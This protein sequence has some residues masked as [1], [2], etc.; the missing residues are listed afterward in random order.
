MDHCAYLPDGPRS[1]RSSC[2]YLFKYSHF[3]HCL[4]SAAKVTERIRL[5]LSFSCKLSVCVVGCL[6]L[7]RW[8][9][10]C[11]IF[12]QIYLMKCPWEIVGNGIPENFL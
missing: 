9:T 12:L 10:D 4:I 5:L 6:K 1:K 3:V 7:Y 8:V 11:C 2:A